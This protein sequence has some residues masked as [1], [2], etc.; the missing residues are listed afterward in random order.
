MGFA[1]EQTWLRQTRSAQVQRPLRRRPPWSGPP[2]LSSHTAPITKCQ[3]PGIF[4]PHPSP[5]GFH[6]TPLCTG[7][8]WGQAEG[9]PGL[10]RGN[11]KTRTP[12]V[13]APETPGS[14]PVPERELWSPF[15]DVACKAPSGGRGL[16]RRGLRIPSQRRRGLRAPSLPHVCEEAWRAKPSRRRGLR[17]P[18][19]EAWPGSLL[20]RGA[21]PERS[22]RTR[23]K[24]RSPP[25]PR[26]PSS[27]PRPPAPGA[28][29]S[30]PAAPTQLPPG[31]GPSPSGSS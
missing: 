3:E 8:N 30:V 14:R 20:D 2:C 22:R 28:L 17:D 27:A 19:Q 31:R 16:R 7:D 1:P 9:H 25:S 11:R 13:A 24:Q 15:W 6:V 10:S 23:P 29:A 4:S 18:S 5:G 12:G 21:R 26:R